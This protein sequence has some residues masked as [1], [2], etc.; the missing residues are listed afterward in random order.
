MYESPIFE[1]QDKTISPKPENPLTGRPS[2]DNPSPA[3][4]TLLNKQLI[5]NKHNTKN[6][7][8]NRENLIWTQKLSKAHQQSILTMIANIDNHD[9]A[10]L[11]LDELAGQIDHI[12]NP[13]GYFRTLLKSY[14]SGNFIPAKAL[15]IQASRKKQLDNERAVERSNQ[16]HDQRVKDLLKRYDEKHEVK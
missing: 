8:T 4:P 3:N 13:V 6:T 10:Q 12:Q 1:T 14:Q 7:T 9:S 2:T 5:P 11:L 15:Q 16:L